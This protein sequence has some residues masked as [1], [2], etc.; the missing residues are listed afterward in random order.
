MELEWFRSIILLH[1][2]AIQPGTGAGGIQF[3]VFRHEEDFAST[4]NLQM[5]KYDHRQESAGRARFGFFE[6]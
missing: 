4:Y 3:E 6:L 2:R 1:W 5:Y